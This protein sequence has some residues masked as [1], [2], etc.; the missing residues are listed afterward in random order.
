MT[1]ARANNPGRPPRTQPT[2]R[3]HIVVPTDL[4]LYFR[5]QCH[6]TLRNTTRVGALS[7]LVEKLL[8][9]EMQ[10]QQKENEHE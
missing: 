4:S 5:L 1:D 7:G 9:Q 8:R 3:W 10:R 2:E 6:D